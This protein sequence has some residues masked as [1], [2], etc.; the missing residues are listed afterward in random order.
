MNTRAAA[1]A[2][3]VLALLGLGSGLSAQT[4][5]A[6]QVFADFV[7][8]PPQG[9][10]AAAPARDEQGAMR[11]A[12]I[13]RQRND[14]AACEITVVRPQ[15]LPAAEAESFLLIEP[16]AV[17]R[18]VL[19]SYELEGRVRSSELL[20]DHAAGQNR[21]LAA[22]VLLDGPRGGPGVAELYVR[23]TPDVVLIVRAVSVSMESLERWRPDLQRL[24]ASL[25]PV[26]R[27]SGQPP[28]ST[29]PHGRL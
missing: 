12:F 26:P 8:I 21:Y 7:V 3:S 19:A 22:R 14:S 2:L 9:F 1:L 16:E 6:V 4:S 29:N 23:R 27:A 15:D 20:P 10:V 28:E 5:A 17:L 24:L 18:A 11:Y 13:R 25:T